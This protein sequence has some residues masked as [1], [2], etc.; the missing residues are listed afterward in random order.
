MIAGLA[1]PTAT[2]TYALFAIA[3]VDAQGDRAG[4]RLRARR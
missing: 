3:A 2:A 4:R 1:L